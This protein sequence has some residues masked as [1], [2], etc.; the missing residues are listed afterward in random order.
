LKFFTINKLKASD[1]DEIGEKKAKVFMYCGIPSIGLKYFKLL[2][3]MK[4]G[5]KSFILPK[6]TAQ[7]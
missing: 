4:N 7:N 2:I 5:N 1:E 3:L 6:I